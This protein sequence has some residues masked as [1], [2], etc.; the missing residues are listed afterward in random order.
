MHEE[1]EAPGSSFQ[2]QAAAVFLVCVWLFVFMLSIVVL[3]LWGVLLVLGASLV[4]IVIWT[5]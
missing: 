5:C 1:E 4:G 3:F 2:T